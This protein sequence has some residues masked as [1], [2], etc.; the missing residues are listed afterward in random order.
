MDLPKIDLNPNHPRLNCTKFGLYWASFTQWFNRIFF[1]SLQIFTF[2]YH[3]LLQGVW[4]IIWKKIKPLPPMDDL[5]WLHL[6][7]GHWVL[8]QMNFK[9]YQ[10]IFAI[11][12]LQCIY[13]CRKVWHVIWRKN[14]KLESSWL[15]NVF[16]KY[17]KSWPSGVEQ[18]F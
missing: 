11:L 9:S 8:E 14:N 10:C 1:W 5:C 7:I 17:G 16:V 15:K 2:R 12:R 13:T 4:T 18:V 3:L 6:N